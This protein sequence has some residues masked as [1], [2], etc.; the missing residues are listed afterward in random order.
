[1]LRI[2]LSCL[3]TM[4]LITGSAPASFA[5]EIPLCNAVAVM[6]GS[7]YVSQF[8]PQGGALARM[9]Q[10]TGKSVSLIEGTQGDLITTTGQQKLVL[11]GHDVYDFSRKTLELVCT[12]EEQQELTHATN[13]IL[14]AIEANGQLWLLLTDSSSGTVKPVLFCFSL[15]DGE[16]LSKTDGRITDL[17]LTAENRM[18]AFRIHQQSRSVEVVSFAEDCTKAE[19][20]YTFPMSNARGLSCD[21]ATGDLYWVDGNSLCRLRGQQVDTLGVL[22]Y[23]DTEVQA[24]YWVQG[25]YAALMLSGQVNL[26]DVQQLTNTQQTMLNIHGCYNVMS[27][28]D[29]RFSLSSGIL[30]NRTVDAAYSA[31]KAYFSIM[32]QDASADLFMVPMSSGVRVMMEKG[33]TVSLHDNQAIAEDAALLYPQLSEMLLY[34]GRLHAV[35]GYA[36][37]LGW[38]MSASLWEEQAAP[39]TWDEVLTLLEGWENHPLNSGI[40]LLFDDA[41]GLGWCGNDYADAILTAYIQDQLLQGQ[42]LDF[43]DEQTLALLR[44]VRGLVEQGLLSAT[45]AESTETGAFIAPR[46]AVKNWSNGV[47]LTPFSDSDERVLIAP[48]AL[49]AG[50]AP[51]VS[52]MSYV[53]VVNPH[54]SHIR[55]AMAYLSY[56]TQNRPLVNQSVVRADIAPE[57]RA[58]V[59]QELDDLQ[60]VK[61]ELEARLQAADEKERTDVENS[62]DRIDGQMEELLKS[63][64]R[65]TLSPKRYE[66]YREAIAPYLYTVQSP[67]LDVSFEETPGIYESILQAMHQYIE[68][69]RSLEQC[70]EQIRSI[71]TTVQLEN[72]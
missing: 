6:D 22:P 59:M 8:S 68:G 37:V 58:D 24:G 52:V 66:Q 19:V 3:L 42:P 61:E 64:R 5:E 62:I 27:E 34:Q 28:L 14:R 43:A 48:P 23:R 16:M 50:S 70:V 38:A 41:Y 49:K 51:A 25:T 33:Y 21:A 17:C 7:L 2:L 72:E 44:R 65:W 20:L 54:S 1:M 11:I 10:M 13:T 29:S 32:T 9:D 4:L 55:E 47:S 67:L 12:L 36:D 18:A 56:L 60:A 69:S 39:T 40:P 53:Y 57:Y 30:I 45:E 71:V 26:Q 35:L 46:A 63:E 31:E 15:E